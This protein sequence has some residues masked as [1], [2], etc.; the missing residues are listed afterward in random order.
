MV[1]VHLALLLSLSEKTLSQSTGL[2]GEKGLT[3]ELNSVP[4]T[5]F[6]S[7][8]RALPAPTHTKNIKMSHISKME[9]FIGV[10]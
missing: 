2:K 8:Q 1:L 7:P 6:F 10:N 9:P 3:S 5:F 4:V